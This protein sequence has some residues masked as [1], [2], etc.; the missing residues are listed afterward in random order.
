MFNNNQIK[1]DEWIECFHFTICLIIAQDVRI[2][3]FANKMLNKFTHI[4][5][6]IIRCMWEAL[7]ILDDAVEHDKP[8]V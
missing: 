7:L 8:T 1:R 3:R 5:C 4:Q 2:E 6:T